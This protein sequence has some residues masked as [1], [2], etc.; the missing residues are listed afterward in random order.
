MQEKIKNYN[1]KNSQVSSHLIQRS[2]VRLVWIELSQFSICKP[3]L[4]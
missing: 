1:C 3:P 2:L 4:I